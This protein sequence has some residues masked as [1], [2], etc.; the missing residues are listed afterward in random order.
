MKSFVLLIIVLLVLPLTSC[1]QEV[2]C[3]IET[4]YKRDL[5]ALV[6]TST[7]E[8]TFFLGTGSV[9]GEYVYRFIE[10]LPDGGFFFFDAEAHYVIVY[11]EN[12]ENA[13]VEKKGS[14]FKF[15]LCPR[16]VDL[17]SQFN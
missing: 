9:S 7:I 1:Q 11:E 4:I 14:G 16:R 3:E 5:R 12:I 13:W 17:S 2:G 15:A 8:G 10:I 6:D